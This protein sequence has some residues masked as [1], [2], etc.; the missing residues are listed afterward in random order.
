MNVWTIERV[1]NERPNVPVTIRGKRVIATLSG[2]LLDFPWVDGMLHGIR[3]S[4]QVNW[5]TVV[6]I[7][8]SGDAI[9]GD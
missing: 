4:F 9:A 8:N 6:R 2:R 3:F 5:T 1:K 7:L